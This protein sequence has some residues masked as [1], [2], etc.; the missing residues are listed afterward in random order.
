MANLINL[1]GFKEFEDKLK[2]LP[3]RVQKL[4]GEIAG[5]AA[6]TWEQGAKRDAP[7]DQGRL[8]NE[9]KAVKRDAVTFEVV[10]NS[11][12]APWMEWGTKSRVKVPADLQAYAAQFK[13]KGTGKDARRHIF[14]WCKRKGI[15]ERL[16]YIIYVSIMRTGVRPHPFF[17][18]QRPKA[19]KQF[20][21]DLKDI[22]ST[23][24]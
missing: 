22:L 20:I 24:D 15:E 12:Q 11:E 19:E 8:K 7:T 23:L 21:N 2:A 10:C 16:W 17:F 18:I 5:F 4:T 6:A 13:G 14:E 1:S 9:I 3:D